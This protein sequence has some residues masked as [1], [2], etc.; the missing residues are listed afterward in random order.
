MMVLFV[1]VVLYRVL[2]E[3]WRDQFRDPPSCGDTWKLSCTLRTQNKNACYKHVLCWFISILL[4][5]FQVLE[6]CLS[7]SV[8]VF[9]SI[10]MLRVPSMPV[11]ALD[12]LLRSSHAWLS[13]DGFRPSYLKVKTLLWFCDQDLKGNKEGARAVAQGLLCIS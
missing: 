2:K 7:V 3:M 8:E 12:I 13:A 9:I 6:Y 5:S 4:D 11:F 10:W 1:P